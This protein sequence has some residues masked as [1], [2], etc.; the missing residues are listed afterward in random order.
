METWRALTAVRPCAARA[1]V[2]CCRGRDV[3]GNDIVKDEAFVT[4][5][6]SYTD[7]CRA[8]NPNF[9]GYCYDQPPPLQQ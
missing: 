1:C 9:V 5:C 7:K 4:A 3:Y 8:K 6:N 2:R